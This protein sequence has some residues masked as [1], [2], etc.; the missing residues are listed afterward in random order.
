MAKRTRS[1]YPVPDENLARLLTMF[2]NGVCG[3]HGPVYCA[4]GFQ[5]PAVCIEPNGH[6]SMRCGFVLW[7]PFRT[8]YG[9]ASSVLYPE[10]DTLRARLGL[11]DE[12]ARDALRACARAAREAQA[13]R[14]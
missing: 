11:T 2:V 12:E 6:H 9:L 3:K 13:V 14:R 5:E 7:W 8:A 10:L 1:S 4:D